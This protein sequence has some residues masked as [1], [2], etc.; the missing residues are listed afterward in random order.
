MPLRFNNLDIGEFSLVTKC[1]FVFNN[2]TYKD[3]PVAIKCQC[4]S[5]D[6]TCKGTSLLQNAT[7]VSTRLASTNVHQA[8]SFIIHHR[9]I[10][11]MHHH[12]ALSCLIMFEPLSPDPTSS[13]HKKKCL[14]CFSKPKLGHVWTMFFCYKMPSFILISSDEAHH[15]HHVMLQN[16]TAIFMVANIIKMIP[17]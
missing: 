9:S 7:L 16:T 17:L 1:P 2:C 8:S 15:I 3:I 14:C 5:Q 11:I 13:F 10:Q 12:A 6:C 4:R